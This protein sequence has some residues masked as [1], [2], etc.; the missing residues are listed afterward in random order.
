M[1][2]MGHRGYASLSAATACFFLYPLPLSSDSSIFCHGHAGTALPGRLPLGR[3]RADDLQV[4]GPGIWE[5]RGAAGTPC[6]PNGCCTGTMHR[7]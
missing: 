4:V 2:I 3:R 1:V 5:L 6:L 7:G